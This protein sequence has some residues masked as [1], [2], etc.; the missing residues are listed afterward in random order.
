MTPL[1]TYRTIAFVEAFTWALLI[2]GMILKYPLDSTEALVQIAGPLHGFAFLVFVV[3]TALVWM[4][5]RWSAGRGVLGLVAAVIPFATIPFEQSVAKK[6]GLDGPW[7]T[8]AGSDADASDRVLALLLGRPKVTVAVLAV[9]VV[10]V[11]VALMAIGGPFA[12]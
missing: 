6:G 8:E 9:G 4:N 12:D 11:F 7:R 10:V 5:N 2:L 1:N 3:V